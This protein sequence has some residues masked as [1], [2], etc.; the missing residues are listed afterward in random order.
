MN[1]LLHVRSDGAQ[2][3]F[4]PVPCGMI[5]DARWTT[6]AT[7]W[8]TK[9]ARLQGSNSSC[10]FP[11]PL[12]APG[13]DS[14]CTPACIPDLD[15]LHHLTAR[16]V[17]LSASKAGRSAAAREDDA[18]GFRAQLDILV[19][20]PQTYAE[21]CGSMKVIFLMTYYI[22]HV[23]EQC[24]QYISGFSNK[25]LLDQE[26]RIEPPRVSSCLRGGLET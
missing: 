17:R 16:L 5:R 13:T 2:R 19:C 15:R 1:R 4:A 11:L 3:P 9:A 12:P 20:Y 24:Q 10:S 8:R 21:I 18:A 6:S 14:F 23:M 22:V 7:P 25:R 26:S